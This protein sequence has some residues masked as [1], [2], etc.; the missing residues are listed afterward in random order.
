MVLVRVVGVDH[1]AARRVLPHADDG[2]VRA[3]QL[4]EGVIG[5]QAA[6]VV[7]G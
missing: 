7:H 2:A 4:H 5:A 3:V 6:E 1:G